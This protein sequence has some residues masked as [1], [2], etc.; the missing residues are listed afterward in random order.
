MLLIAGTIKY[1]T[2]S[3]LNAFFK[4]YV[5]KIMLRCSRTNFLPK[6]ISAYVTILKEL[7]VSQK[8]YQ[9]LKCMPMAF[10]CLFYHYP[11]SAFIFLFFQV[12]RKQ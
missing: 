10:A 12:R 9:L 2:V 5:F 1:Q 7:S 6:L 3:I 11:Y 4:T 8:T